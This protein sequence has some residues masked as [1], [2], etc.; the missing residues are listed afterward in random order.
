MSLKAKTLAGMSWS[1]IEK[2][3]NNLVLFVIGI[4]LARILSPTDY[5]IVGL[6]TVFLAVSQTIV[7]SGLSQSL[8][9]KQQ[10]T[11]LD[12]NTMFYANIVF[13][14]VTFFVLF[15]GSGYIAKF[16]DKP[17]LSLLTKIMALNL[18]VN[19]F[20]LIETVIL[21]KKL[22]FKTQ[23]KISVISSISGGVIGIV[24]AYMG[25]GYWSLAIKTLITNLHRVLLL[26]FHSTWRPKFLYSAASFKE[27]FSFGMK[28]L[29]VSLIDTIYKNIYQMIIGKTFS[30]T[31]LGLYTRAMQFKNLPATNI[32]STVQRVSYPVL[33][34]LSNDKAKM[35]TGY[36][37]LIRL[38]YYITSLVMLGLLI[39]SKEVILLLVGD[40]W[41]EAIPYLQIMCLAGSL[42]PLHAINLNMMKALDRA[43]LFLKVAIYKKIMV[44]PVI[45]IG[46]KFGM[47]V[48]LWG[49]VFN[50][51]IAYLI[52]SMY[53]AKL[54]SYS[55]WDQLKD[56]FP[57]LLE[58]G[59]VM[60]VAFIAGNFLTTNLYLSLTI[61]TV[62]ALILVVLLGEYGRL[63]DYKEIKS[64]LIE[65]L[66]RTKLK[67]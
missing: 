49:M 39:C 23:A 5:G 46:I 33:A 10:C 51:F 54:I 41:S 35:R 29:T 48:L 42:Y 8:I 45:V 65:Q 60:F 63:S 61:K 25:F 11:D 21:T 3:S 27:M 53:S 67:V 32:T 1:F 19:S 44:I 55:T 34:S 26:R 28:L 14:V 12:Y 36:H 66:A 38:T 24:F 15:A 37:K 18:I 13:G 40:K 52:N 57:A 59:F 22:D 58:N 7:D 4:V 31:Q 2:V 62:V 56:I 20:G 17:E 9:R 47:I 6:I 30:L 64:L 43:D 50:S 16:Y